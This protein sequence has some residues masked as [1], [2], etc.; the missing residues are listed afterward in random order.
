MLVCCLCSAVPLLPF[1][2]FELTVQRRQNIN[3]L[4]THTVIAILWEASQSRA[5]LLRE[6]SQS[7]E[8]G[9]VSKCTVKNVMEQDCVCT[10][11]ARVPKAAKRASEGTEC[12]C[13]KFL[14]L[15]PQATV[16]PCA[17]LCCHLSVGR[18]S[19]LR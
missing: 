10:C 16:S 15:F 4:M 13:Q 6:A 14:L 17:S 1:R 12:I 8:S 3:F 18:L 5:L 7:Y 9:Q 19:P 2:C 11:P